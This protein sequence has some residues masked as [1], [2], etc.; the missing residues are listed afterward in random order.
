LTSTLRLLPLMP[1]WDV[2][3]VNY[4]SGGVGL[5]FNA[6]AQAILMDYEW[7]A[8]KEDQAIGRLDRIGQ[9]NEVN[10]HFIHVEKTIDVWMKALIEEKR[11]LIAGFVSEQK[12]VQSL[13]DALREGEL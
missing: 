5:N 2:V 11:E 9:V 4:K 7:N 3:L 12:M 6:A 8:G 1:R 10:V 13:Y